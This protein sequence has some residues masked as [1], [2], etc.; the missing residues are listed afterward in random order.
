TYIRKDIRDIGNI[1]GISSFNKL[2]EVLASQSGQLLNVLE[3]SNTLGIDKKTVSEY[4]D[5]LENTFVIKRTTPFH[6][7]IRS[8]LT[9]S[10]KVFILDT[11]MMHLLWLKEFPKIIFGSSFETFVFLELVK[12]GRKVN[13]WRTINKQEV[14]FI[15]SG[16]KLYAIEAKYK[17]K[18]YSATHLKFFSEK[19]KC[20]QIV[21]GMAGPKNGKYAWELIKYL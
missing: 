2:L 13:F 8:E 9:K 6:K 1:R 3:L 16:E 7:N 19:Y 15:L 5:L 11:G 20:E 14:D 17:F 10:P 18:D 12:S 21:V 4:L